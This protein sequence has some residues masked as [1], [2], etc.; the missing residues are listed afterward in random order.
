MLFSHNGSKDIRNVSEKGLHKPCS[1]CIWSL[2]HSY[3]D[4]ESYRFYFVM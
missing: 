4:G 2:R 1:L 3:I